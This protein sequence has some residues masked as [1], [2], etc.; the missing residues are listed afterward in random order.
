[1]KERTCE[2]IKTISRISKKWLVL[3]AAIAVAGCSSVVS[4]W[5]NP[6]NG[7]NNKWGHWEDHGQEGSSWI[8]NPRY[9][10]SGGL[11]Y[12]LP[13]GNVHITANRVDSPVT[14]YGIVVTKFGRDANGKIQFLTNSVSMTKVISNVVTESHTN[15]LIP[16]RF[17]TN[18]PTLVYSNGVI[19]SNTVVGP[20]GTNGSLS[21]SAR[22]GSN[23][24]L[25]TI[26]TNPFVTTSASFNQTTTIS[27]QLAQ[28]ISY[29]SLVT[30]TTT[31]TIYT[32]LPMVIT[33]HTYNVLVSVDYQA[34]P[35]NLF[36]LQPQRDWFHDDSANITVDTRGLLA[37]VNA[38]NADQTGNAIVALAQAAV[39]SF[40]L[41]GGLPTVGGAAPPVYGIK[42]FNDFEDSLN[43]ILNEYCARTNKALSA[44]DFRDR[45]IELFNELQKS[46]KALPYP[47]QIDVSFNPFDSDQLNGASNELHNAGLA[48]VNPDVFLVHQHVPDYGNW[49]RAPQKEVGGVF[50][51]PPIPYTFRIRD[52]A[53]NVVSAT[54]LL[55]NLSP[56]VHLDMDKASFVEAISQV[57]M[58]NG[59][60]SSYSFSKPSSIMALATYPL[61]L[62]S[63]ITSSVTNLV[64]LRINLATGQNTLQNLSNSNQSLQSAALLA[65]QAAAIAQMSNAITLFYLSQTNK[66]LTNRPPH[67]LSQLQTAD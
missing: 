4:T 44:K 67:R 9:Q 58:T 51:R 40:E 2:K 46:G 10:S 49:Y 34:D 45:I 66:A 33:N 25:F 54:V 23:T 17:F 3:F 59:F 65:Q 8:A 50:Y 36:L 1:M 20:V 62:L 37:S 63:D 42:S 15:N 12:F 21:F 7:P 55:P 38:T 57:T 22:S 16:E 53:S 30:N 47:Q 39:Q 61:T 60:V 24:Q 28:P 5:V 43:R 64:Q 29:G 52:S 35:S 48:I 27:N 6:Q 18:I 56:I 19:N 31:T 32:E 13:M 11:A 14:N 41:A 26:S